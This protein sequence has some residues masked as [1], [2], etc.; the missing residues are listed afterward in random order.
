MR[1]RPLTSVFPGRIENRDLQLRHD[2]VELHP[3]GTH[4]ALIPSSLSALIPSA[5]IH[6]ALI[7]SALIPSALI[8]SALIQASTDDG[9]APSLRGDY[10]PRFQLRWWGQ[11]GCR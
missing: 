8:H 2:I 3:S 11:L 6:S 7:P 10:G 1:P 9:D 4:I 5:L